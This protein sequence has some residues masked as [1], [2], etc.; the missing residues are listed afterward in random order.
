MGVSGVITGGVD[1]KDLTDFLGHEIGVG[2]TGGE[3]AGVTLLI[4]EGF[5]VYPMNERTFRLLRSHEG[6]QASVDGTTQIR[7]RMLRPEIIIPL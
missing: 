6:R 5:G 1:Q 4:M 3:K 2:V 7:Q